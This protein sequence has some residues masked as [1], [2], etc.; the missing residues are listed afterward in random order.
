MDFSI[1]RGT[2]D[3]AQSLADLAEMTF[4]LACPPYHTPENIDMH[5]AEV[6]SVD[7]FEEYASEEDYDLFVAEVNGALIGFALLDTLACD[8]EEVEPLLAGAHPS[9]ELSKL[10]VHPAAH[11][12]GAAQALFDAVDD[13]AR[14]R[15]AASLWLTVWMENARALAFYRR[16]GFT[17]VGDRFYPVGELVDHDHVALKVFSKGD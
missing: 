12:T 8:D 11:G 3:D 5:L 17:V 10:Y 6:L 4:P 14:D 9:M 16:N 1:R 7:N 15:S 13:A 2:V